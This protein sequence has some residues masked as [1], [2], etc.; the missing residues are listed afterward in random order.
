MRHVIQHVW[1]YVW[2]AILAFL[3]AGPVYPVQRVAQRSGPGTSTPKL[4][5]R[6]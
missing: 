1:H 5:P 3:A 6:P 4:M 2:A